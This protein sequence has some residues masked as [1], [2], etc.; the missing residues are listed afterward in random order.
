MNIKPTDNIS[1]TH[2]VGYLTIKFSDLVE[3]FGNP[4]YLGGEGD[5]VDAEWAFEIDNIIVTLYNW[6]NG[7]AFLG[8][9][10]QDIENITD[11]N[12]GG[13]SKEAEYILDDYINNFFNK[14]RR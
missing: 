14:K 10:G 9:E 11:W 13:K 6:K 8:N 7:K 5:K 1:G 12:I 2:L 3:C 4:H